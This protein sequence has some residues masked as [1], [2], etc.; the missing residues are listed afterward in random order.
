MR[1]V[2]RLLAESA[3]DASWATRDLDIEIREL[4]AFV[5]E[6]RSRRGTG[7]LK[8]L[9]TALLLAPT[10]EPFTDILGLTLIGAG[11]LADRMGHPLTIS[12]I[13]AEAGS[14][15]RSILR[16]KMLP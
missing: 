7:G 2:D 6:A 13:S 16:S 11:A 9:G 3:T 12:E 8:R 1:K 4:R 15:L 14:L 10:P 5:G